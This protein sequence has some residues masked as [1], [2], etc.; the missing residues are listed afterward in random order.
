MIAQRAGKIAVAILCLYLAAQ[1][2]FPLPGASVPQTA[3]TLSVL[4][5]AVSLAP[6]L[7]QDSIGVIFMAAALALGWFFLLS[8]ERFRLQPEN[9]TARGV[10]RASLL[11]LPALYAALLLDRLLG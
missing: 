2:S 4:L 7:D 5:V 8:I 1:I 11:Y 10:L 9:H 3:Q 6:A